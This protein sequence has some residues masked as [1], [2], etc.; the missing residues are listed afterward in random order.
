M[1]TWLYELL[2]RYPWLIPLFFCYPYLCFLIMF[3]VVQCARM[4]HPDDEANKIPRNRDYP[5][6]PAWV[7]DVTDRMF[8]WH[9]ALFKCFNCP[10]W[11][12]SLI[13]S[14]SITSRDQE[15]LASESGGSS[16]QPQSQSTLEPNCNLEVV[17]EE[18]NNYQHV[19]CVDDCEHE[20][21]SLQN[22]VTRLW[23]WFC[24]PFKCFYDPDKDRSSSS[25][26]QLPNE[27]EKRANESAFIT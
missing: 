5:D 12:S 10:D 24:A 18:A 25:Y 15:I 13:E 11:D 20:T 6:P 1:P 8:K 22:L 17:S 16:L 27:C 21:Y 2:F 26:S 23:D 3:A 4:C 14:T 9:Y 19:I 7:D